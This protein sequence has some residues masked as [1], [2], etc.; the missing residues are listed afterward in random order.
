MIQY[1][2]T[3]TKICVPDMFDI[4]N[5]VVK[6][7]NFTYVQGVDGM[8]KISYASK[9]EINLIDVTNSNELRLKCY[10]GEPQLEKVMDDGRSEKDQ[11]LFVN[12]VTQ[13]KIFG[14]LCHTF[15]TSMK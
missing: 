11:G 14:S 4:C 9:D 3:I 1:I 13:N 5:D 15:C 7:W 2:Y 6:L 12:Y 8:K 10:S